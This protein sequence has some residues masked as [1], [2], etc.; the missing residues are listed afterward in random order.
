M[1]VFFQDMDTEDVLFTTEEAFAI[2]NVDESVLID[3]TTW[4]VVTER[5]FYYRYRRYSCT[6]WVKKDV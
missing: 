1:R 5:T 2:P 4:Y 3:D 6:V